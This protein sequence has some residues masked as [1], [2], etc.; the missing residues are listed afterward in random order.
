M[1]E[2]PPSSLTAT[3]K[4]QKYVQEARKCFF[5]PRTIVIWPNDWKMEAV[6]GWL[7]KADEA[8]L[9][10]ELGEALGQT[11][12]KIDDLVTHLLDRKSYVPPLETAGAVLIANDACRRRACE[13]LGA[14]ADAPRGSLGE[15]VTLLSNCL[16]RRGNAARIQAGGRDSRVFLRPHDVGHT[17][18][19]VREIVVECQAERAGARIV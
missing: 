12:A 17:S 1:S 11:F 13:L 3:L 10:G 14:M 16:R 7:V 18:T 6:V 4:D 8:T 15:E 19:A 9:L 2:V 5:V